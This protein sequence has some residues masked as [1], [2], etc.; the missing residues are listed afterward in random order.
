M[1]PRE[2]LLGFPSK[3]Q[4]KVLEQKSSGKGEKRAVVGTQLDVGGWKAAM[5][6]GTQ[7]DDVEGWEAAVVGI[8]LNVDGSL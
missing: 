8:Q 6:V 4:A 1:L 2:R 7:L 3:T 5:V